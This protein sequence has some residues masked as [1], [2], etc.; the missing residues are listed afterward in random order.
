MTQSELTAFTT[1]SNEKQSDTLALLTYSAEDE[2]KLRALRLQIEKLQA[3]LVKQN[4]SLEKEG[5]E[6]SVTWMEVERATKELAKQTIERDEI[7]SQWEST[8]RRSKARDEQITLNQAELDETQKTLDERADQV[9]AEQTQLEEQVRLN[10]ELDN[11]LRV[12]ERDLG[13]MRY[14]GS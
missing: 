7:V 10:E 1:L 2:A 9:E 13:T 4:N 6:I 14:G 5:T 12:I 3:D 11:R 8:L